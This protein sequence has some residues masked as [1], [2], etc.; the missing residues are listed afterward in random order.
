MSSR[1]NC[2]GRKK[3]RKSC[4]LTVLLVLL[5]SQEKPLTKSLQRGEDP[6]FDQVSFFKICW[7]FWGVFWSPVLIP[8]VHHILPCNDVQVINLSSQMDS[9]LNS[10]D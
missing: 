6:Q 9:A 4:N 8:A 1:Q 2:G 3:N 5:F 7:F 10:L